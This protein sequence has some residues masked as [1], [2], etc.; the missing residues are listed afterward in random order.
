[1]KEQLHGGCTEQKSDAVS[2]RKAFPL[3]SR[4]SQPRSRDQQI[5][6]FLERQIEEVIEE[7]SRRA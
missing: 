1:M 3:G 2:V 6:A 4:R 7:R 5:P